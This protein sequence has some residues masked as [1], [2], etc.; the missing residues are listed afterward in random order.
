MVVMVEVVVENVD[1]CLFPHLLPLDFHTA[2]QV[3]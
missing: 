1:H 2:V 3:D